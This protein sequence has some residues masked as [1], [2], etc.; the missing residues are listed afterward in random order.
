MDLLLSGIIHR[1]FWDRALH[2]GESVAARL[3]D[4]RVLFGRLPADTLSY[5]DE[6]SDQELDHLI[7]LTPNL[8]QNN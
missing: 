4:H 8:V 5:Q 2:A 7:H 1:C 3:Y 6:D